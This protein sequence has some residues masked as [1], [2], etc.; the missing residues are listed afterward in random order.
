MKTVCT[1]LATLL[2]AAATATAADVA[3][4]PRAGFTHDSGFDQFHFGGHAMLANL[5]ANVHIV[6]S[7]EVGVGDGTLF[8][9]NGDV[10]YEFT[11]YASNGW[12]FYAGGGPMLGHYTKDG[13][14]STDFAL[15]LVVGATYDLTQ[16]REL[17]T[18]IR[19][20][21]EDAPTVKLTAGLTFF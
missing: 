16:S 21:V 10:V 4:G 13:H 7:L 1:C 15:N 3:F 6:P 17:L 18:E 14:D 12:S 9:A 5:T 20:G 19:L 2:I 8:A 11:E